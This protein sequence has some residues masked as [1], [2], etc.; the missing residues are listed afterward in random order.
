MPDKPQRANRAAAL[1]AES[2]A[3]RVEASRTVPD[4][5]D[6]ALKA[7]RAKEAE[8]AEADKTSAENEEAEE[9]AKLKEKQRKER[10][11]GDAPL[12]PGEANPVLGAHLEGVEGAVDLARYPGEAETVQNKID[13]RRAAEDR[14]LE[15]EDEDEDS[16]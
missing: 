11:K 12:E 9:V 1:E 13:L 10:E 15:I 2:A 6:V 7:E 4:E 5:A 8:K 16:K 3:A 14:A